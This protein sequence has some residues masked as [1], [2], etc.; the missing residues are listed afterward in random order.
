MKSSAIVITPALIAPT[1]QSFTGM[2][3]LGCSTLGAVGRDM[4]P[5]R[6]SSSSAPIGR[7]LLRRGPSAISRFIIAV[8]ADPIK[9]GALRAWTHI[10]QKRREIAPRAADRNAPAAVVCETRHARIYAPFDHAFPTAIFRRASTDT[11]GMAVLSQD[12]LS[13][14][15]AT[16]RMAVFQIA[17]FYVAYRAAI[18]AT[19]PAKPVVRTHDYPTV[20]ALSSQVFASR[21]TATYHV[22]NA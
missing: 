12:L 22:L 8:V 5:T 9:R 14:A 2:L 3:N 10:A 11:N 7:L 16:P 20:K 1:A 13:Q 6:R 4:R 19:L 21:H 15:P 17:R 18:A